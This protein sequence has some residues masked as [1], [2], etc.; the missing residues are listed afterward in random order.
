MMHIY[1]E[2]TSSKVLREQSKGGNNKIRGGE[3]NER[4]KK[5]ILTSWSKVV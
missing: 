1:I 4:K 3:G 2:I 5:K